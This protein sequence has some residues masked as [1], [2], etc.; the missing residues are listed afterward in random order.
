MAM[1]RDE[2]KAA[3]KR[4]GYTVAEFADE[5]GVAPSTAQQWGLRSGVPRWAV[6]VLAIMDQHGRAILNTPRR[7]PAQSTLDLARQ[8]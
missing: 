1:T 7:R 6:R 5:F 4:H 2:F 3:C 8:E